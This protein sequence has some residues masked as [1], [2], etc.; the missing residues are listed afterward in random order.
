M[1]KRGVNEAFTKKGNRIALIIVLNYFHIFLPILFQRF[2]LTLANNLEVL[3]SNIAINSKV[4]CFTS[5]P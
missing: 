1:G 3:D 5:K 4:K 2:S